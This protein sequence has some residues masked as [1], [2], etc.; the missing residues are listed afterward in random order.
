[1]IRRPPRSTLFPYTTLFR[2]LLSAHFNAD[3]TFF[4]Y[5]D[6]GSLW[7]GYVLSLKPGE[8]WLFSKVDTAKI[9]SSAS[10]ANFFLANV[11]SP[12]KAGFVDNT[13]SSTAVRELPF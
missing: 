10:I 7:P 5:R 6:K 8:N 9:E 2:A 11:G 13:V 4:A 12:F 1:M 3:A